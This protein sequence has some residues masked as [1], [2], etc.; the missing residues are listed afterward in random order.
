M[1]KN[2]L[3][4]AFIFLTACTV[5]PN[6]VRPCAKVPPKFKEAPKGWKIARPN[7]NFN[8]GEWWRIFHDPQLN[9]LECR[10]NISNQNIW[11][12][13]EQY[14]QA[15]ALVDEARAAYFPTIT[16]TFNM[17]RQKNNIS[18]SS[19]SATSLTSSQNSS[20]PTSGVSS[21]R[22]SGSA[23]TSES[24]ALNASWVV[25]IWGSVRRNVEASKAGAQASFAA[26]N[27]ARLSAQAT[28]AQ[29]YFELRGLDGDQKLLNDTVASYKKVLNITL[30]EYKSGTVSEADVLQ[31]K[32]QLENAQAQ[33]VNVGILRG[34]YEHAIAVL[35]GEPAST[36]SIAFKPLKA[37]PP[38]IP[39]EIP[40]ELLERRPDVAQ[41]ERL[42]AQANA[43]IGV[44]VA[45]F[46]PTLTLSGAGG[47][48]G[49]GSIGKWLSHPASSWA[50]GAQLAETIFEGG[51]RMATVRAAEANYRA[52]VA[53]YRQTVLAA[54]Q[55]VEDNLVS[56]RIL[57]QQE[58]ILEKAVADARHATQVTLN[59]YRAG[60][61]VFSTVLLAETAQFTAEKNANDVRYLQ[62]SSA[63]GLIQALGGG[64][65]ACPIS[66]TDKY[67]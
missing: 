1:K 24:L 14:Q 5:G 63:A 35:I 20:N 38:K 54:F 52:T 40:S 65:C 43:Q 51:L 7:D 50:F 49:I 13:Y 41:A 26:L 31:A 10:L 37:K 19:S 62:M 22:S 58:N 21:G 2:L 28:L 8:R 3:L 46:Y 11:L 16:S 48:N 25:D 42:A 29:T 45:A 44:A 23:F 56:L 30:N 27:L 59:Q 32:T 12:A 17:Q 64:W 57:Q 61:V 67:C 55:N 33:A 9:A 66:S 47:I 15:R 6:Y 18:S 53:S 34:Q 60:T 4:A 39:L 36:F